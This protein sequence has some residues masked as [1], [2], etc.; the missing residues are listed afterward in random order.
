MRWQSARG[1]AQSKTLTRGLDAAGR[2]RSVLE[3]GGPP[4][5]WEAGKGARSIRVTGGRQAQAAFVLGNRDFISA[6]PISILKCEVV[7]SESARGLA[8]SRTLARG[9]GAAGRT[10]SILECGGPPPL[11]E[12]D[13][14]ERYIRVTNGA[15]SSGY[16]CFP[17]RRF[18]FCDTR[19]DVKASSHA[20]Q[21]RQRAGAVQDAGARFGCDGANAKRLGVRW[22]STAFHRYAC[23]TGAQR[24]RE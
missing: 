4:P 21:K 3:C 15:A 7:R 19:F 11:C 14:G 23:R 20:E 22:P 9:S 12:V 13:Q 24:S 17:K 2:T 5:L 18:L 8:Q 10:R 1:L 6:T 16:S